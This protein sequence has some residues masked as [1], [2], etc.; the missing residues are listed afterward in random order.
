MQ[1]RILFLHTRELCYYSGSYFLQ[2]MQKATAEYGIKSE[3]M[4]LGEDYSALEDLLGRQ[5]D[6]VVDINSKLPY[7]VLE[8]DRRFLDVLGAPFYNYIVDHPLYHHPGLM[9]PLQN[10]HAIAIDHYHETYM[11]GYYPHLQQVSYL[12]LG[13]TQSAQAKQIPYEKR[14][15]PLLF[16]GTYEPEQKMLEK[17][18]ALCSKVHKDTQRADALYALGNALR[19]EMLAGKWDASLERIEVPMEEALEK[20]VD[21]QKL[22]EGYYGVKELPVLMNY[23]YL[24]DKYVRN[25]RRHQVLSYVAK[26]HIPLTIV[27][28]GWDQTP[29]ADA[30]HVTLLGAKRIEETYDLLAHTQRVLDV[31]PL[32]AKG[33]HDR[34]TSAAINGCVCY[35]DMAK[36]VD[37]RWNDGKQFVHYSNWEL[38]A[39]EELLQTMPMAEQKQIAKQAMETAERLYSWKAHAAQLLELIETK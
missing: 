39:L 38:D 33:M 10:Y 25:A 29:L 6:G 35:S 4:S 5:Y 9:F 12:P 7:F 30:S 24:V 31:N 17:F 32:F 2:Q 19:E 37:T 23:L 26:L 22:Q 36:N 21:A 14:E 34:V 28:E 8:D 18:R 16:S 15:I 20:I 27:G 11:R 3:Y 13:V 1:K